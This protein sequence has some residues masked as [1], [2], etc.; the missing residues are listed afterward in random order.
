[1]DTLKSLKEEM[2]DAEV[3]FNREVA[4][5]EYADG[6]NGGRGF[7]GGDK[8]FNNSYNAIRETFSG[9]VENIQSRLKSIL[10]ECDKYVVYG[11]GH[12]LLGTIISFN[13]K[14]LF[15]SNGDNTLFSTYSWEQVYYIEDSSRENRILNLY[16]TFIIGE[17][18]ERIDNIREDSREFID[19][20][21]LNEEG[22]IVEGSPEYKNLIYCIYGYFDKINYEETEWISVYSKLLEM[23]LENHNFFEEEN[24][25][26]DIFLMVDEI[27]DVMIEENKYK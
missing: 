9:K 12:K 25:S 17:I 22:I 3:F 20:V 19:E 1:M 4:D 24:I 23:S 18:K 5:L 16:N 21:I 27:L 26:S 8:S 10:N 7:W 15:V 14:N 2:L 6:M 13:D 11:F